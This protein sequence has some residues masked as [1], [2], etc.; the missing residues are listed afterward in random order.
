[1]A[2]GMMK[3]KTGGQDNTS[4]WL[5]L[6]AM[7]AVCVIAAL[8]FI[9]GEEPPEVESSDAG[10]ESAAGEEA[11][12]S[13]SGSDESAAYHRLEG[14]WLRTDGGYI[15]DL[16]WVGADGRVEAGYFNPQPI[17]VS[18]AEASA[19]G[20]RIKVMVELQDRG[21]PGCVYTLHYDEARDVLVGE[22][23]QAAMRETFA[24]EFERA[25]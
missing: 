14:R 4:R 22:Y 7:A 16:R 10:A 6:A 24:V 1:M 11:A 21:Y 18:R 13:E 5:L 12:S 25:Q 23:Y 15:L 17:F 2:G 3:Q 8:N 9:P 19:D 20:D